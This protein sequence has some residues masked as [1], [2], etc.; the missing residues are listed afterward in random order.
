M[1]LMAFQLI[2][3]ARDVDCTYTVASIEVRTQQ[4]HLLKLLCAFFLVS[5]G[6]SSKIPLGVVFLSDMEAKS[7]ISSIN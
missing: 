5:Y 2:C 7:F 6:S 1:L 3:I 4:L